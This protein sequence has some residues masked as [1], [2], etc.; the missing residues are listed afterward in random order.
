MKTGT[1]KVRPMCFN[2]AY[3]RG[4]RERLCLSYVFAK[5]SGALRFFV[6]NFGEPLTKQGEK[7]ILKQ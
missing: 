3:S 2:A 6:R 5:G 4:G 1:D 7:G